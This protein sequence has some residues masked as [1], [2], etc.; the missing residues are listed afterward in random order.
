MPP[1]NELSLDKLSV[2]PVT[3]VLFTYN[4]EKYVRYA[5]EDLM[6]QDI[7]MMTVII[8]DDCSTDR[9]FQIIQELVQA[10]NSRFDIRARQNELRLG[11]NN[12]INRVVAE[13]S[14]EVLI[15]FAGDDRFYPSRAR[16]LSDT[17]KKTSA[18]LV[19][20][21]CSFITETD[22]PCTSVHQDA[23]F[24]HT[25]DPFSAARSGGLFIGATAA[26]S[27]EL[28]TRYG[29]LP[30]SPYEDLVLGFRATLTQ[31]IQ[32]VPEK[33]M[34]YR[35]GVGQ[36][37]SKKSS[38]SKYFHQKRYVLHAHRQ[39][40]LRHKEKFEKL[41]E[42]ID[43]KLFELRLRDAFLKSSNRVRLMRKKKP[44]LSLCFLADELIR[45][46]KQTCFRK[47]DRDMQTG[48]KF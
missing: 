29:N 23:T 22:Q 44:L 27:R 16:I 43:H 24:Y 34:A 36:S 3:A 40:C 35:V 17:Q 37:V 6:D 5:F 19:H 9:T 10:T 14:P 48:S 4:Q 38:R 20:S 30:Q 1:Q 25:T 45:K 2:H 32:Y 13:F 26:W 15:P 47:D 12:H 31:E 8:S 33:L 46:I 7:D 42:M 39:A 18:L 28:F 41:I 11:F 21:G